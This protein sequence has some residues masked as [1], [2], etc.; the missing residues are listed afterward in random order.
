MLHLSQAHT[1]AENMSEQIISMSKHRNSL[2]HTNTHT[3]NTPKNAPLSSFRQIIYA[4]EKRFS[5]NTCP[6]LLESRRADDIQL[7]INNNNNNNNYNKISRFFQF[8][9]YTSKSYIFFGH[10]C[11]NLIKQKKL[12]R[13]INDV[14]HT[15][16][17]KFK[18]K[19]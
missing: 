19:K 7:N 2:V 18:R 4:N 9:H 3:H 14:K 17:R 1:N 6:F 13:H 8:G 11:C 12:L 10:F 15:L 5:L 16:C